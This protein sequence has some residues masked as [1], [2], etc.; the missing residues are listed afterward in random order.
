MTVIDRTRRILPAAALAFTLAL[1]APTAATAGADSS[2][3]DSSRADSSKGDGSKGGTSRAEADKVHVVTSFSILADLVRAIGGEAVDVVSLVGPDGD[4]HVFEPTPQDARTLQRARVLVTNGLG[5]ESWMARLKQS[6]G[7]KGQEVVATQGV[8]PRRLTAHAHGDAKEPAHRDGKRSRSESGHGHGHDH[9]D[10]DPHAWQ[11]PLNV[12]IYAQNIADGLAKADPPRA[13]GYRERAT[14]Y[15]AD[16]KAL[17]ARIR[18]TLA[19]L[20]PDR[21]S[22][23]TTHDAF[24]YYADTYGLR[25]VPARGP[26]TEAEPSARDIAAL[27]DQIRKEK[28]PAVFIENIADPRLMEQLTRET[29]AV[30]G[31]RLYSDALSRPGGPAA[32]YVQ[33]METNTAE[34]FKA[35]S[36]PLRQRQVVR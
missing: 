10:R 29:D 27:I 16:L 31:G 8:E 11:N 20:P 1:L 19:A 28:I 12:V 18:E 15:A 21:R 23:V 35:L 30:I 14:A 17:D 24:G 26:S 6:A 32:S 3:A 33:L 34:L 7:F 4:A 36:Q 9:G 5:F 22:V 13:A 2:R 25:F